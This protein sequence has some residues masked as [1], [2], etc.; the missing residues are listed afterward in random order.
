MREEDIRAIAEAGSNAVR[1]PVGDWMYV[2]YAPYSDGCWDGA[3]EELDRLLALCGKYGLQVIF[4][5]H[6]TIDL[7]FVTHPLFPMCQTLFVELA[8][9][10]VTHLLSFPLVTR[11]IPPPHVFT[12]RL[13]GMLVLL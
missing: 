1:V 3:L 4:F 5:S 12:H 13:C 11:P 6:T 10:L 2:P 9:A 8:F 7:V